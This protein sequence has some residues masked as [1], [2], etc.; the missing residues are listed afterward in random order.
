MAQR[1]LHPYEL[2]QGILLA[3]RPR[4]PP[5]RRFKHAHDYVLRSDGCRAP[6]LVNP[7]K[8]T[9]DTGGAGK[10]PGFA[11]GGF[12]VQEKDRSGKVDEEER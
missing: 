1:H 6:M 7:T 8:D 2:A 12:R 9:V 3:L 5:A 11:S 10:T 4:L